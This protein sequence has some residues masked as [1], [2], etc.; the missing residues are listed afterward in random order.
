[1]RLTQLIFW[2]AVIILLYNISTYLRYPDPV[3]KQNKDVTVIQTN[4]DKNH[5][6]EVLT[7]TKNHINSKTQQQLGGIISKPSV[8]ENTFSSEYKTLNSEFQT[9]Q[10][11]DFDPSSDEDVMDLLSQAQDFLSIPEY[12]HFNAKAQAYLNVHSM[13]E[14]GQWDDIRDKY[15]DAVGVNLDGSGRE[16]FSCIIAAIAAAAA[17]IA[18]AAAD[19]AIAAAAEL[20]TAAAEDAGANVG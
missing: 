5:V 6:S 20:L 9:I 2:S 8:F 3:N 13:F 17:A 14:A 1:M 12:N 10:L 19:A 16:F 11:R 15:S 4:I 18:E 7:T